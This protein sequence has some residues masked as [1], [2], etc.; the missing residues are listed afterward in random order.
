MTRLPVLVRR[1]FLT[2]L[3][4][5]LPLVVT[6]WVIYTGIKILVGFTSPAV[7]LAFEYLGT[8]PPR[9]LAEALSLLLTAVVLTLLGVAARSYLGKQVGR[10]FE[11]LLMRIPLANPIYS[12]M[13]KLLESF[14]RQ[15]GFQR[16]VLVEF[17]R[18]DCWGLGFLTGASQGD[19]VGRQ[20]KPMFN[21]FVPTTPNPTSGYL[22]V[23]PGEDLLEL[24]I[25][26]EEGI[27]FVMSGGVVS[28]ELRIKAAPVSS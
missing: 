10:G 12:S 7:K 11:A 19:L 8:V 18:R 14:Q 24:D 9:F 26:V 6:L 27:T 22:V 16:V 25:T 15:K 5:V 20:G 23:V 2:G 28:P 17:P 4:L 21:V 13:K 1:S 3:L